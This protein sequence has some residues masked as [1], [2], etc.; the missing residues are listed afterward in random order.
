MDAVARAPQAGAQGVNKPQTAASRRA[1]ACRSHVAGFPGDGHPDDPGPLRIPEMLALFE[2]SRRLPD[3]RL[4]RIP[5]EEANLYLG[6][7]KPGRDPGR[8]LE[9]FPRPV[10][11]TMKRAASQPLV[12]EDPRSGRVDHVGGT[13][14]MVEP[15][16]RERGLAGTAIA[17][18]K[19]S[20]FAHDFHKDED[21]FKDPLWL[22][23]AWKAMPADLAR[24]KL[25]GLCL[26]LLD[27]MSDWGRKK[28]LPGQVDVFRID[29]TRELYGHMNV[30]HGKLD[31]FPGDE[32]GWQPLLD[33]LRGVRVFVTTGENF[34]V[35]ATIGGREG[36]QTLQAQDRPEVRLDLAW[37][38]PLRFA[39]VLSGDASKVYRGRIDRSETPAFGHRVLPLRPDLK[40]RKWARVEARDI[41]AKGRFR[42]RFGSGE[43]SETAPHPLFPAFCVGTS[44]DHVRSQSEYH[45]RATKRWKMMRESQPWSRWSSPRSSA[46]LR[47]WPPSGNPAP[48][49]RRRPRE[50]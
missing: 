14:D 42:N 26:D 4:L 30:D 28:Q 16:R 40:G 39:E 18:I 48:G 43:L 22:G 20:N 49:S 9:L 12:E 11:F 44:F 2:E 21:F 1:S 6:P 47:S 50:R 45:I 23:A 38:F 3:D 5:G 27:G 46:V 33:P 17:R 32:Y 8:S 41:A 15:L 31:R 25:E 34:L 10:T 7:R 35:E 24:S 29:H 36:G 37:T 13:A 19:A